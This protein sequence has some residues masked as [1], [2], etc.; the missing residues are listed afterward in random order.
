MPNQPKKHR[1][2]ANH[3]MWKVRIGVVLKLNKLILV[4]F[5]LK[6]ISHCSSSTWT[7]PM[8]RADHTALDDLCFFGWAERVGS[9]LGL[10]D[11]GGRT[12]SYTTLGA[13]LFSTRTAA[14][15]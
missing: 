12:A 9:T 15:L 8:R 11:L 2:N 4:V 10:T 3:V 13:P 5:P 6:S 14:C 1:K 7:N